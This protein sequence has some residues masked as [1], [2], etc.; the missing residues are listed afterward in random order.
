MASQAPTGIGIVGYLGLDLTVW[1]PDLGSMRASSQEI[2]R[3]FRAL[4]NPTRRAVV[5]RLSRGPAS[6]SELADPFDMALPSFLQH[7]DVLEEGGLLRSEKVGRVRTCFLVP[8][9]LR[10]AESWIAARRAE[11]ERRL[12]QLDAYLETLDPGDPR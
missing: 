7:L 1:T 5:A 2:E 4:A 6:V 10:T 11:W 3:V 9:P 12:D 8:T